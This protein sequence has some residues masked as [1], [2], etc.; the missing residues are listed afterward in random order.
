MLTVARAVTE[1]TAP[2]DGAR[3]ASKDYP[4]DKEYRRLNLSPAL[5]AAF[6]ELIETLEPLRREATDLSLSLACESQTMIAFCT[7]RRFSA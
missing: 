2:S 5:S 3:F 7:C 6:A 4:K 1:T